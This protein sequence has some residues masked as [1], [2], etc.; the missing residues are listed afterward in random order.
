M[1]LPT[2]NDAEGG[3]ASIFFAKDKVSG[4]DVAIRLLQHSFTDG[5]AAKRA[6]RE[7]IIMKN[8]KHDNIIK[9]LNYFV[10][11]DVGTPKLA[12]VMPKEKCTLHRF[13]KN[14]VIRKDDRY[15][16]FVQS[17]IYNTLC[18]VEYLHTRGIIHRDL[19]M[20]NIMTDE[21]GFAK[22]IDFGLS[23]EPSAN[24]DNTKGQATVHY[25]AP[26]LYLNDY[27]EKVDIWSVGCIFVEVLTFKKYLR[28][29]SEF[30]NDYQYC[31]GALLRYHKENENF[32]KAY[33]NCFKEQG[34]FLKR[35]KS[36][37]V[38]VTTLREEF[39][40]EKLRPDYEQNGFCAKKEDAMAL[41]EKLLQFEPDNRPSASEA[42]KCDFFRKVQHPEPA[43][44][45]R[46]G[47]IPECK[48]IFDKLREI[49]RSLQSDEAQS[50]RYFTLLEECVA[51]VKDKKLFDH[52]SIN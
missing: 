3:E 16:Y 49:S 52:Y 4:K 28:Q 37:S 36:E 41:I 43:S 24:R 7:L 13:T 27:D 17:I 44:S 29:R 25:R 21:Y 18:G 33:E 23:R 20:N 34:Y 47:D 51:D 8:C 38:M 1:A 40:M 9:L 35:L 15:M 22:I 14:D 39:P 2:E 46:L 5:L 10:F 30:Q 45:E 6:V 42:L 19:S 50:Q 32:I 48:A 11:N 12:M 26:E 31:L